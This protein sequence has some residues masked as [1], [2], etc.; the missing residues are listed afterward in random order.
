MI[1]Q[2]LKRII[3]ITGHYGCGKTNFAVNLALDLRADGHEVALA[4][5]DLVNP[6]FRSA[7]FAK[8]LSDQG[9]ELIA[10]IFANTNVDMPV[11]TGRLDAV[12]D[13]TSDVVIDVGGDDAGATALGRYS[14]GISQ[15]GGC[16]LLYMVNQY[17]YLTGESADAS[18]ILAGIERTARL[19]V[20]GVIN[21]SHLMDATTPEHIL[22]SNAFAEQ[23]ARAH[24]VPLLCTAVRR[25]LVTLVQ[26]A[27]TIGEIYPVTIYVKK[28]WEA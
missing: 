14:A 5:L 3:A 18:E 10:P 15:A 9:I 24:N 23:I 27:D 4:D 17:R 1:L 20:T 7:D 25:D 8:L 28:P 21:T 16:S 22:S 11:L 6:Y 26:S 13:G 12:L 19:P 2:H